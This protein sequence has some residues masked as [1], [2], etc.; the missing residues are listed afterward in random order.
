MENIESI[1]QFP[2][3]KEPRP[4]FLTTLCVLSFISVGLTILSSFFGLLGGPMSEDELLK[5]KIDLTKSAD[6]LRSLDVESMAVMIEKLQ[7]MTESINQHFYASTVMNILVACVGLFGV[8]SMWS[9]K[10]MG[11]Q[12][13]MAYSLLTV[14]QVYFF[15]APAD[16]PLFLVVW[17]VLISALFVFL[18]SRNV[19]WL[20]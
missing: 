14:I 10:K 20:E 5:Q 19:K 7:R 3:P 6:E 11:F 9:G 4:S 13:Y 16:I 1:Q 17:N 8:L 12:V 18:Y 15:V 2:E